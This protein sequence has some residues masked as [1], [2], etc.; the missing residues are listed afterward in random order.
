M[1]SAPLRVVVVNWV[2]QPALDSPAALLAAWPDMPGLAG[3]LCEAGAEVTV[4]QRFGRDDVWSAD[5]VTWRFVSD[6][7][8]GRPA[9]RDRYPRF[10]QQVAALAPE[11]VHAHSL[12]FYP[13]LAAL[14]QALPAHTA[15]LAQHHAEAH[16]GRR[17]W[18]QARALGRLDGV[19]FAAAALADAWRAAGAL[20]RRVPVYEVMEGSCLFQPRPRAEAR[21]ESGLQGEPAFLWVGRLDDNKDPLTMLAGLAPVLAA[22]P[23]AR[24]QMVFTDA[25]LL[26]A[27]ERRLATDPELA[28]QV[29]LVGRRPRAAME[30]IYN[31]CDYYVSASHREGSGYALAEAMACG[32]VPLVTDIP[33][34]RAMTDGGRVGGLWSPGQ[35]ESLTAT[36]EAMLAI[37][38]AA[39]SRAAREQFEARLSWPAIGRGLMAAYQDVLSQRSSR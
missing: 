21:V 39:A 27:V 2:W 36:V 35:A 38:H 20:P 29:T 24:L 33:S 12:L 16:A 10:H 31:S 1:R 34:F 19:V 14:R 7:P 17:R 25:P 8:P 32:L 6:G 9:R 11:V 3:G 26:P 15:L 18:F 23:T 28:R 13:Q 5:G 37:D 4:L 22:R 30:A